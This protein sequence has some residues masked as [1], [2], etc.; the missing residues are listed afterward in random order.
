M[1]ST[2]VGRPSLGSWGL[3]LGNEE[4]G[5]K[6]DVDVAGGE[7]EAKEGESGRSLPPPGACVDGPSSKGIVVPSGKEKEGPGG[8]ATSD[9][10]ARATRSEALL[11]SRGG[12]EKNYPVGN[13]AASSAV[14]GG[15]V[16]AE[17]RQ[18]LLEKMGKLHKRGNVS[19]RT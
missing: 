14:K 5:A 7:N 3:E 16:E 18:Q 1:R 10:P 6:S 12:G 2:I 4:D 13:I 9:S 15:S 8:D 11:S 17:L 19:S